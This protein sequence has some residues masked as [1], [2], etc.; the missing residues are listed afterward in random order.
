M[1][2]MPFISAM[3]NYFGIKSGQTSL[4]F[5]AEIKALTAEDREWFKANLPKVGYEIVAA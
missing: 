4:E 2:Q 3:K 5:M 1:K